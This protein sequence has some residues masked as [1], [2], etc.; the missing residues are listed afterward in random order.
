MMKK[1]GKITGANE[2][3]CIWNDTQN[4]KLKII[5]ITFLFKFL[6]DK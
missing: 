1:G 3:K 5:L 4:E 2:R 6:F